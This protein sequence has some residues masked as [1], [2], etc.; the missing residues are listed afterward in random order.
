M[1]EI[2]FDEK[3]LNDFSFKKNEILRTRF[4]KH[5]APLFKTASEINNRV[6]SLNKAEFNSE[7]EFKKKISSIKV[8]RNTLI[9]QNYPILNTYFIDF[10]VPSVKVAIEIDGKSHDSLFQQIKDAKKD[11]CLRLLGIKVVRVKFPSF[12]GFDIAAQSIINKTSF[13]KPSK[14]VLK[15]IKR[16]EIKKQKILAKKKKKKDME[17]FYKKKKFIPLSKA[18][19]KK[20]LEIAKRLES[21]ISWALGK[22]KSPYSK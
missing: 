19:K 5:Y 16:E 20:R 6:K 8:F 9:F 11:D 10:Y 17:W 2:I 22:D 4:F 18:R 12:E 15:I 14:S 13:L 1:N 21:E 3:L 7:I